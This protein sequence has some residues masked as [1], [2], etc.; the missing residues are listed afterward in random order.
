MVDHREFSSEVAEYATATI[1]LN[2]QD[3]SVL[4][5]YVRPGYQNAW[6][7]RKLVSV[8]HSGNGIVVPCN[9][10]NAHNSCWGGWKT[11]SRHASVFD[12]TLSQNLVVLNNGSTMFV[13]P[14]VQCN[15]IDMTFALR[16]THLTWSTH[17]DSWGGYH[18]PILLLLPLPPVGYSLCPCTQGKQLGL[19]LL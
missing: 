19:F 2:N 18:L 4:S 6:A 14:R 9:C 17:P 10:F 1:R 15:A 12:V 13:R 5:V 8:C 3:V 7:P 16:R 11:D